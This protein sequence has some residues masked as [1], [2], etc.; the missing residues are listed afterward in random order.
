MN[1]E[2]LQGERDEMEKEFEEIKRQL[3]EDTD[4]EIEEMKERYVSTC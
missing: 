1:L 4:K 2:Q 3:E